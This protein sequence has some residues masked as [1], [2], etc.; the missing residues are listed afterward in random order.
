M[1]PLLA[2][3][4]VIVAGAAQIYFLRFSD[5]FW[6]PVM[7]LFIVSVFIFSRFET[8]LV[9]AM[10]AGLLTDIGYL[11]IGPYIICYVL[12]VMVLRNLR[13]NFIAVQNFRATI[14]MSFSALAIYLI[15]AWGYNLY[16]F[17]PSILMNY[18]LLLLRSVVPLGVIATLY[19]LGLMP[20]LRLKLKRN[21]KQSL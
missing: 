11:A 8:A 16:I 15:F 14:L 21:E 9:A 12:M 1:K 5:W 6:L 4:G 7:P 10:T 2:V 3:V 18:R 17:G 13:F 19:S 20:F